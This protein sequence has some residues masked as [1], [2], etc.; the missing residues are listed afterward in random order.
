MTDVIR[1]L[2]IEPVPSWVVVLLVIAIGVQFWRLAAV[3]RRLRR[4]ARSIANMD[5][6]ADV[7]DERLER[8]DWIKMRPKPANDTRRNKMRMTG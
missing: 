4:H 5:A 3:E 8:V 7:T 1:F 6:W 2:F